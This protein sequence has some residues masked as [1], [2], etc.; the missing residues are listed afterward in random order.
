MG[1]SLPNKSSWQRRKEMKIKKRKAKILLAKKMNIKLSSI[2]NFIDDLHLKMT[3]TNR[4]D[5]ISELSQHLCEKK[6]KRLRRELKK[7]L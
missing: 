1:F 7:L 4:K 3:H 2:N 6:F 5:L